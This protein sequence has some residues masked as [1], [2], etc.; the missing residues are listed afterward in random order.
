[1]TRRER[2]AT[3]AAWLLIVLAFLWFAFRSAPAFV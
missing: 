1:M 3:R 2:I